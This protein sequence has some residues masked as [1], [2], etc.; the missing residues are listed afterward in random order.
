MN[1]WIYTLSGAFVVFLAAWQTDRHLRRASEGVGSQI[2]GYLT[3]FEYLRR[4]IAYEKA[5]LDELFARCPSDLLSACTGRDGV[6]RVVDFFALLEATDFLSTELEAVVA[7][8]AT[9][10][11]RGYYEEQVAACDKYVS[12]LSSLANACE[13][14]RTER[15]RVASVFI[16]TAAAVLVL[17]LL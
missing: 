13:T 3:L 6:P 16:Y 14:K 2:R 17:L 8:A 11:G 4:G 5:P 15:T 10:I 9:K 12:A 7:E 1:G